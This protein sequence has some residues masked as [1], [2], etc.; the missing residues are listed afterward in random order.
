MRKSTDHLMSDPNVA[1]YFTQRQGCPGMCSVTQPAALVW[2]VTQE[3]RVLKVVQL[4]K[5]Q[6][7][8][9]YQQGGRVRGQSRGQAEESTRFL[10]VHGGHRETMDLEQ[11][12]KTCPL[13]ASFLMPEWTQDSLAC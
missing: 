2:N 7:L 12:W 9:A 13:K 1:N 8:S 4:C 11:V 3:L 10:G 6:F 5:T